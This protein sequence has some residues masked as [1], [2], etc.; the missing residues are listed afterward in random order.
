M[1][2]GLNNKVLRAFLGFLLLVSTT[3]YAQ[4]Y[5]FSDITL[6]DGLPS[7]QV[8]CIYQDSEGFIWIGTNEGLKKYAGKS[9]ID[10]YAKNSV[11]ASRTIKSI[12]ESDNYVWFATDRS[13]F[14]CVG[15]Y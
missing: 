9:F 13:I 6:H 15:N 11:S 4:E 8:N 3:F 7:S 1:Q 14:K 10:I 12:A 2:G 5:N